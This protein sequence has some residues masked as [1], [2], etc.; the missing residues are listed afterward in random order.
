MPK[1]LGQNVATV[2]RKRVTQ[3]SIQSLRPIT[4]YTKKLTFY[5]PRRLG[6]NKT[7]K[8][9]TLTNEKRDRIGNPLNLMLKFLENLPSRPQIHAKTILYCKYHN[10]ITKTQN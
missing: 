8:R 5:H 6:K 9:E 3:T 2:N 4:V 10:V 7:E 1:S